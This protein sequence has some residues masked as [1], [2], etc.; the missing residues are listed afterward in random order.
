MH[1]HNA[2]AAVRCKCFP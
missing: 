1:Y 2:S